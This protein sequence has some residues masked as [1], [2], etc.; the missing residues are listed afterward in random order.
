VAAVHSVVLEFS[1]ELRTV[2]TKKPSGGAKMKTR[3][4]VGGAKW[5]IRSKPQRPY[6]RNKPVVRPLFGRIKG[7]GLGRYKKKR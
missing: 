2:E 3:K 4:G 5:D 6:S 1:G 7:G